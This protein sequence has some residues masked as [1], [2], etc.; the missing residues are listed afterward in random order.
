MMRSFVAL[1]LK[2]AERVQLYAAIEP[3]RAHGVP[4]RWVQPDG[5]HLTLR[6]LG[7]IEGMKVARI[8]AVLRSVAGRHSPVSLRLGG[9]GAFPSL[10]RASVL[11][12]GVRPDA[13]LM[14]L[15]AELELALSPLGYPREQ[16]PFRPHITVG[17]ARR[18]ARPPDIERVSGSVLYETTVEVDTVD[19]MRSHRGAGGARYEPL[20]RHGLT[21]VG[22]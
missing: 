7:D 19:L 8:D 16:K 10:R 4:A 20:L 15:H 18:G 6:F 12:I 1:N 13:S 11:W 3:L 9:A 5:L 2:S 22:S 17:R 21:G 14:A